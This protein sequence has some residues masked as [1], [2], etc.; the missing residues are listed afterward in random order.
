MDGCG[1]LVVVGLILLQLVASNNANITCTNTFHLNEWWTYEW[2]DKIHIRQVHFNSPLGFILQQFTLVYTSQKNE[3]EINNVE[4]IQYFFDK[5]SVCAVLDGNINAYRT[6]VVSVICCINSNIGTFISQVI[7]IEICKYNIQICSE[8]E[9]IRHSTSNSDDTTVSNDKNNKNLNYNEEELFHHQ[10][11]TINTTYQLERVRNMFYHAFDNYLTHAYPLP[12]LLPITCTGGQ[13]DLI[14]LPL[15]TLIDTLDT[16][17]VMGDYANFRRS[18][19]IVLRRYTSFHFDVNVSVFETTIRVLGGLL[20]AHLMAI[21]PK[22]SIYSLNSTESSSR[23]SNNNKNTDQIEVEYS[24]GLLYLAIDLGDR[25]L[26]AFDTDTGIPIGTVNLM[27]G[28]PEGETEIA[29]TAG[30]G[31]LLLEF[32]VLSVLSGDARYGSAAFSAVEA[33]FERRSVLGLFGR[34]IHTG[35]GNSYLSYLS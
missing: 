27:Y 13:F 21:D 30:A 31:S 29:S 10:M 3:N 19:S 17:V 22:L 11:H 35:S 5:S 4:N 15:V 28:I 25:L 2:C 8:S 14:K 26:Q 20:S 23:Q 12:E 18:V 24:N 33:L 34:H 9:C 6:A 32:Q 16:L 1:Y 7:E